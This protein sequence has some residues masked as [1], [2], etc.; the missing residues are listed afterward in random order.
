MPR[1]RLS[2]MTP[3]QL[4]LHKRAIKRAADRRYY[5]SHLEFC[6]AR[7]RRKSKAYYYLTLEKQRA[8]KQRYNSR[9]ETKAKRSVYMRR[10]YHSDPQVR[11]KCHR[12]SKAYYLK[13]REKA[14]L[15]YLANRERILQRA[16]ELRQEALTE[17][18]WKCVVCEKV[19]TKSPTLMC[20]TCRISQ[21]RRCERPLMLMRPGQRIHDRCLGTE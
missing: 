15:Y 20:R 13:N 14:R 7:Q 3:E 10:R 21:C 18:D 9:P 16:K 17:A 11:A 6:R 19:E 4:K 8:R 2:G 12:K 5:Y 1:K